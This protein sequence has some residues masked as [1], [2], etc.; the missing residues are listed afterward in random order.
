MKLKLGLINRDEAKREFLLA[1]KYL[2][3]SLDIL[4]SVLLNFLRLYP[5][6]VCNKLECWYLAGLSSLV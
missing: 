5:T 6:S 1:L 4:V 3:E 2:K